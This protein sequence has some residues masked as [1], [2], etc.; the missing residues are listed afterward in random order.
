MPAD[1]F[2][3]QFN[4]YGNRANPYGWGTD[5]RVRRAHREQ[6]VAA[7]GPCARDFVETQGDEAV[8]AIFA[9]SRPV[10]VKLVEFYASGK[11]AKLPSP[12]ALLAVIAQPRHRDDVALWAIYHAGELVDTDSFDAYLMSPLEYALGLKQL[13][14]GAAEARA[15]RLHQ[16][17][18]TKTPSAGLSANEKLGI[19]VGVGLV[20]GGFLIWRRKR[21]GIC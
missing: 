12:R 8:A 6:A 11:M 3:A 13:A 1:L 16:A 20:L 18:M 5:P 2:G 21:S 15:R 4:P 14:A 17:A 19:V 10:A 9:C 7:V